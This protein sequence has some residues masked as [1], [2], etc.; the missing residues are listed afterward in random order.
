MNGHFNY[1]VAVER[2]ADLHRSAAG[3]R[4]AASMP[5]A[6]TK[7]RVPVERPT[8]KLLVVRRYPKTV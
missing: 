5:R 1:N 7:P 6:E 2:T 8:R 3:Q 4:L